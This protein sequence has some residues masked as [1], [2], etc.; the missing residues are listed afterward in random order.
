MG[1]HVAVW[2][3]RRP[4]LSQPMSASFCQNCLP[5]KI[6]KYQ[7]PCV[8]MGERWQTKHWFFER[9]QAKPS[10]ST[11]VQ[12]IFNFYDR[13]NDFPILHS[14][15][16]SPFCMSLLLAEGNSTNDDAGRW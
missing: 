12:D 6:E 15:G 13:A 2:F 7:K 16:P 10:D 14:Y 1:P 9:I 3:V 11:L 4:S 5:E 8:G